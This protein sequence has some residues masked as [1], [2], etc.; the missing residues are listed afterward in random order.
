MDK[1]HSK[2]QYQ[3]GTWKRVFN[4]GWL[5]LSHCHTV[6]H[7]NWCQWRYKVKNRT[8]PTNNS[9]SIFWYFLQFLSSVSWSFYHT[10]VFHGLR[11]SYPKIFYMMWDYNERC[12][13]TDFFLSIIVTCIFAVYLRSA[14]FY[15]LILCPATSLKEFM[16]NRNF[17]AGTLG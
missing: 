4:R 6:I 17:L 3:V 7:S 2:V 12:W 5:W 16:S 13:V 15:E 11:Y 1:V 9:L 14:D 8:P 10:K